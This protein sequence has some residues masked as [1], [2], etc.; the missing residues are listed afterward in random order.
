MFVKDV[1]DLWYSGYI[2]DYSYKKILKTPRRQ[3]D[4]KKKKLKKQLIDSIVN[5]NIIET[6]ELNERADKVEKPEDATDVTKQC[7][8]VIRTKCH[9]HSESSRKSFQTLQ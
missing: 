9:I 8:D 2:F 6:E 3:D 4:S 1:L 5:N 7:E